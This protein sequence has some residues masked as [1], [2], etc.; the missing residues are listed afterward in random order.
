MK[1][2]MFVGLTILALIFVVTGCSTITTDNSNQQE[3]ITKTQDANETLVIIWTSG[4][5]MVAERVAL[6]FGKNAKAKGWF[7]DVIFV[8]WGPSAKLAAENTKIQ[9]MIADM[10]NAGVVL[11]ACLSCSDAYGVTEQIK[12][13]GADVKY[14]GIPTAEYLKTGYHVLT[15]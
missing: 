2:K 8:I 3:G 5:P 14:M 12:A 7:K 4:D 9:G 6:S 15:F 11:E 10:K 13:L 1:K